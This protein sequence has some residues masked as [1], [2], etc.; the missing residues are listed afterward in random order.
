MELVRNR[1]TREPMAPCNGSSPE[2]AAYRKYLLDHGV[3]QYV[4]WH[5]ALVL[6]PLIITPEQLAEG[7]AVIDRALEITDR[8]VEG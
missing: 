7:F 4:H 8:A 1:E 2:M 6:P 5:T 3:Y